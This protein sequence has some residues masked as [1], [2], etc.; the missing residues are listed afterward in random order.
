MTDITEVLKQKSN[1]KLRDVVVTVPG[2][3]QEVKCKLITLGE[4]YFCVATA[5]S[6]DK[7]IDL[8]SKHDGTKA[9]PPMPQYKDIVEYLSQPDGKFYFMVPE[10]LSILEGG[11]YEFRTP[12]SYNK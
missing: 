2:T 1:D 8:I 7:A 6:H 4:K 11:Q 10:L 12:A 3:K 5:A 9:E